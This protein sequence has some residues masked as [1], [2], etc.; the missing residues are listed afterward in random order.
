MG[1][2]PEWVEPGQVGAE[3][4]EKLVECTVYLEAEPTEGPLG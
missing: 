3:T 2:R 4:G 1:S